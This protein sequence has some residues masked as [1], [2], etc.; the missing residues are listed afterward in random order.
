[1]EEKCLTGCCRRFDSF[2]NPNRVDTK[3]NRAPAGALFIG[4][5][6]MNYFIKRARTFSL[7]VLV[8]KKEVLKAQLAPSGIFLSVHMLYLHKLFELRY[9]I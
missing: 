6:P 2:E 7:C 9:F 5:G 8:S 3:M 1:M 4:L